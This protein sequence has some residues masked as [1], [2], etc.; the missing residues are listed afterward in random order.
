MKS[1]QFGK[2][3]LLD[4]LAAGG[5]AEVYLAKTFGAENVAKF[6]AIKRILPQFSQNPDFIEMFKEEAKIA[7]NLSHSNIVSIFEFGVER[8]Q[9]YL[10]MEYVE[11]RNLRQI[12]N[13]L[14]EMNQ[15]LSPDQAVYIIKEAALGLDNAHRCVDAMARPLNIIHR[16]I[17]PQNIMINFEGEIKIVDFGIAK[18][19]SQVESTRAGTLKGKFSYMSP[20]QAEGYEIDSRTDIFSLGIVL[21]ELLANERLFL[22]NNE[23]NTLKK[24]KECHIPSLHKI[25]PKIPSE[26]E[27]IVTKAL[28][29]DKNLR[30]QTAAEFQKDLNRFLN[31]QYPDFSSHDFSF[32]IKDMF[33]DEIAESKKKLIDFAQITRLEPVEEKTAIFDNKTQTVTITKTE[34]ISSVPDASSVAEEIVRDFTETHKKRLESLESVQNVRLKA[35]GRY[36]LSQ[37]IRKKEYV[38]HKSKPNTHDRQMKFYQVSNVLPYLRNLII[39]GLIASGFYWVYNHHPDKLKKTLNTAQCLINP[40]HILCQNQNMKAPTVATNPVPQLIET[41]PLSSTSTVALSVYSNPDGAKIFVNNEYKGISPKEVSLDIPL[42][43]AFTL[44]LE[45]DG[46]STF[47]RQISLTKSGQTLTANLTE[48]RFGVLK[49][50][51]FPGNVYLYINGQLLKDERGEP[52][53]P[54]IK[55][56][57]LPANSTVKVTAIEKLTQAIDSSTIIIKENSIQEVRLFPKKK[58]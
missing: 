54:P 56:L 32:F 49:I 28:A 3:I 38:G 35:Q 12:V 26:L 52:R 45:K 6:V 25:D 37:G 50:E 51:S 2:F 16:D 4:K 34:T 58:R 20:E 47:T 24:I 55:D 36:D 11:G 43:Q 41:T 42:N 14:K 8:K 29:R 21:W 19:E 33:Q 27:K 17:S 15:S 53:S 40:E 23:L 13:R 7:I 22:S 39:L 30:Y 10:A 9:F 18:A 46:Y 1:E 31:R 48:L 57:K 5:M 44:K